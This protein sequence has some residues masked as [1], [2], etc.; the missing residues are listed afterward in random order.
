L[1]KGYIKIKLMIYTRRFK[2]KKIDALGTKNKSRNDH[3]RD[4]VNDLYLQI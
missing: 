4:K 1:L 2:Q 3:L